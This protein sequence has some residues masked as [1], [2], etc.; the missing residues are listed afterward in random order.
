MPSKTSLVDGQWTRTMQGMEPCPTA[1]AF[2]F[3]CNFTRSRNA[4]LFEVISKGQRRHVLDRS[5]RGSA[6][7]SCSDL[8]QSS[9]DG[10]LEIITLDRPLIGEAWCSTGEA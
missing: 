1:A 8:S 2:F 9:G 4:S 6:N 7:K 10:M 3:I 5:V